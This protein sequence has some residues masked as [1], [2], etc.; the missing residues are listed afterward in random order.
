[1]RDL[2]VHILDTTLR[3]GELNPCVNYTP[4]MRDSIG[5]ALA[6]LGTPR[7]EFSIAY[8][9]RGGKIENIKNIVENIH[10]NFNDVTTIVQCRALK[11]DVNIVRKD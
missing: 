1:M 2:S 11:E 3:E 4:K 10:S 5:L 8:S 7:I 9:K 6:K